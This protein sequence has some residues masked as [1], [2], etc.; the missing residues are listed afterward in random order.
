V[1]ASDSP[2][3]VSVEDIPEVEEDIREVEEDIREVEEVIRVEV[4]AV[5]HSPAAATRPATAEVTVTRRKMS[6]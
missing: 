4:V 5:I 6:R 3:A 2:A 1:A